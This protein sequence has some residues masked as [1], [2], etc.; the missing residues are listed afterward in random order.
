MEM[1]TPRNTKRGQPIF[2]PTLT[3]R[4]EVAHLGIDFVSP[5]DVQG[6]GPARQHTEAWS[7]RCDGGH[8][9]LT[10]CYFRRSGG[11]SSLDRFIWDGL[12]GVSG[13]GRF[14]AACNG[15]PRPAEVDLSV[16][17]EFHSEVPVGH[18]EPGSAAK[19]IAT[20]C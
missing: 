13:E 4:G 5:P 9:H 8:R 19:R 7:F 15:Q 18:A 2:R 14:Q 17:E 3:S 11:L 20:V 6:V 16:N 1:P 12:V 10:L